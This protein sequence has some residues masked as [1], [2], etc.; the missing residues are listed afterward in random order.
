MFDL[1]ARAALKRRAPPDG[2][3]R[4]EAPT[5]SRSRASRRGIAHAGDMLSGWRETFA[6]RLYM[7]INSF[8]ARAWVCSAVVLL[9]ACSDRPAASFV[10]S[11]PW[12]LIGATVV[13]DSH[14]HTTFSDGASS[15]IDVAR[16]AATNG[17][18]AL[19]I[20]D[21]GDPN[22]RAAT[23]QYFDAIDAART[24]FPD[25]IIFAGMEW[26]VPP[27]RRRE[28]VTLLLDRPHE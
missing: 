3:S 14:T 5:S 1:H 13:L 23:P 24:E 6:I 2:A 27:Y 8:C 25:L 19:A 20:T 4:Q 22:L 16:A 28:H 21:H 26:N 12:G 11:V 15:P 7:S 9:A 18:G 10:T 17:C